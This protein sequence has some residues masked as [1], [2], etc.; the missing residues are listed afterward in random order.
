MVDKLK[1]IRERARA[2]LVHIPRGNY[3]QN[4]LRM[5]YWPLRM[6]SL[7]RKAKT[8]ETKESILR[9]AIAEVR[10]KYPDFE[11]EYDK[12]FFKTVEDEPKIIEMRV[13]D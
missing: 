11:P 2:E 5:F 4:E 7:G 3:A 12:Q 1:E 10:K 9:K 13:K 6:N 8:V